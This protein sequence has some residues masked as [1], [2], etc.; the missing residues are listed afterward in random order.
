LRLA[1]ASY[2]ASSRLPSSDGTGKESTF[3][4]HNS[5]TSLHDVQG[6]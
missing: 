2:V 3:L 5:D 4:I 6:H 1:A